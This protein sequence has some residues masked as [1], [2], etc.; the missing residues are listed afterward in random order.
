MS[1]IQEFLNS[2]VDK[3]LSEKSI[4]LLCEYFGKDLEWLEKHW[5]EIKRKD[6]HDVLGGSCFRTWIHKKLK[7]AGT[8]NSVFLQLERLF[9]FLILD[10]ASEFGKFLDNP[11]VKKWDKFPVEI[12]SGTGRKGLDYLVVRRMKEIL[13]EEDFK[14]VK[15]LGEDFIGG[16]FNPSRAVMLSLMLV[17]PLRSMQVRCLDSGLGDEY[18]YDFS[19]REIVI[20][21]NGIKGR[22]EGIIQKIYYSGVEKEKREALYINTNKSGDSYFI[23]WMSYEVWELVRKQVEWIKEKG[24]G[25]VVEKN[26]GVKK[27]KKIYPLFLNNEKQIVSRESLM[28]L[29]KSLCEEYFYRF[30]EKVDCD[31]HSL[32][33]S[34]VSQ[35]MKVLG[36]EEKVGGNL[37]GQ[38]SD[39][40]LHYYRNTNLQAM[41]LEKEKGLMGQRVL[42]GSSLK[43]LK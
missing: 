16:E 25:I 12:K 36:S 4:G 27:S 31:L 23:P 18:S 14:F 10:Y 26:Y 8:K 24:M 37:S 21:C 43:L 34:L 3:K 39:I 41:V 2:G 40:V 17:L 32:R 42:I 38:S 11:V 30:G 9:D 7:S 29:W 13:M 15:S 35:G 28:R 22:K 33:V 1:K 20:N 5:V 6:I 19:S